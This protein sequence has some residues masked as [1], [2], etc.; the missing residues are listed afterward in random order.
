[1][2]FANSAAALRGMIEAEDSKEKQPAVECST[3][4]LI[5]Q[6]IIC[7]T[8]ERGGGGGLALKW[9]IIASHVSSSGPSFV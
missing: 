2:S 8:V 5:R 1:M 6:H 4:A 7:S 3:C 9:S